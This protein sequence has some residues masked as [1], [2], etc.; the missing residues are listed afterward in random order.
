MITFSSAFQKHISLFTPG[1]KTHSIA[2]FCSSVF[3]L[4]AIAKLSVLFSHIV[5]RRGRQ[6]VVVTSTNPTASRRML[7]PEYIIWPWCTGVTDVLRTSN[8]GAYQVFSRRASVE[9]KCYGCPHLVI[10]V[11]LFII[12]LCYATG[13]QSSNYWVIWFKWWMNFPE[14][15][16][17]SFETGIPA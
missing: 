10:V 9:F 13:Q 15:E 17:D 6:P 11:W 3:V 7:K 8:R 12:Y 1:V 14:H 16:S 4:C 2:L 5:D